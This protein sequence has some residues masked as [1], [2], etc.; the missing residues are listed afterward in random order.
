MPRRKVNA[1]KSGATAAERSDIDQ[2]SSTRQRQTARRSSSGTTTAKSSTAGLL[3]GRRRRSQPGVPDSTSVAPSGGPAAA[4]NKGDDL[5]PTGSPDRLQVKGRPAAR[6][7]PAGAQD[8]TG[9]NVAADKSAKPAVAAKRGRAARGPLVKRA[10]VKA[11]E[12]GQ[13]TS[14]SPSRSKPTG[15]GAVD[16]TVTVEPS[17]KRG[18]RGRAATPQAVVAKAKGGRNTES[19][20]RSPSAHSK[21]AGA[22][23]EA[24]DSAG[25]SKLTGKQATK[26]GRAAT[27][28]A[29]AGTVVLQQHANQDPPTERGAADAS[30][31]GEED[32]LQPK[33]KSLA[34]SKQPGVTV[35]AGKSVDASNVT[36]KNTTKM[37]KGKKR[38]R[39]PALDP[40]MSEPQQLE[41]QGAP[42]KR[43]VGNVLSGGEKSSATAQGA[44][45]AG[46]PSKQLG[47]VALPSTSAG[48]T[49]AT[50][51]ANLGRGA[52]KL[53]AKGQTAA[54]RGP[55]I[56]NKKL[57][58]K[59]Q[60]AASNTTGKQKTT[61]AKG[62]P[63]SKPKQRKRKGAPSDADEVSDASDSSYV[64]PRGLLQRAKRRE[65][66]YY[67]YIR[68]WVEEQLWS[69]SDSEDDED[70]SNASI[71]SIIPPAGLLQP[72]RLKNRLIGAGGSSS[73]SDTEDDMLV[74]PGEDL[75]SRCEAKFGLN[76][77]PHSTTTTAEAIS[78]LVN[79]ASSRRL[80][81]GALT[82]LVTIVNKLFAP[83]VDVLPGRK[84]LVKALSEMP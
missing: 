17:L 52:K 45:R 13:G 15:G 67:D 59:G 10:A 44:K 22:L 33:R 21:S 26:R 48:R 78:M 61:A 37:A 16:S 77:L 2:A 20:V 81:W 53:S 80:P 50:T 63:Q 1:S 51:D 40:T 79:F 25:A 82:E 8:M 24:G 64:V 71:S 66:F 38:G 58:A 69:D 32:L 74:S 73:G 41:E 5:A 6:A 35:N 57:P 84:A 65:P 14:E 55:G 18:K 23:A 30:S 3:P 75:L 34:R 60:T 11:S 29:S 83:A 19:L 70:I 56:Q 62:R 39:A 42:A 27:S 46:R 12:P 43:T 7:K 9:G 31:T 54:S 76:T 72:Y 28:K 47:S 36:A 49:A 4:L 68:P